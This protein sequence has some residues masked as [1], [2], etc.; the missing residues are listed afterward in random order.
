MNKDSHSRNF[1]YLE[2]LDSSKVYHPEPVGLTEYLGQSQSDKI[3]P[4]QNNVQI[5]LLIKI[6]EKLNNIEKRLEL[7][8]KDK[9]IDEI[10]KKFSEIPV[11]RKEKKKVEPLRFG[12]N[13]KKF[14]YRTQ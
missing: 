2:A 7:I 14:L 1:E 10:T 12:Q 3:Y 9:A 4:K 6:I 8:E 5:I 11:T 13:K